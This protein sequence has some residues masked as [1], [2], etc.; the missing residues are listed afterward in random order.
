MTSE[1]FRTNPMFLRNQ[2]KGEGVFDIPLLKKDEIDLEEIALIGYDKL[3][4]E[5]YDKIVHF[6]LDDYKFEVLWRDPLPRLARLKQYKAVLTPNYSI[7]SEMPTALKIYNTFRSR[8]CGAFFQLK[9]IKVIPTVAWGEP[10]TFWFC[11]DGIPEGSIVAVSTLGVRTE[12]N[13]FLQGYNELLRRIKPEAV[14]CYGEP[15]E[16]MK[17]NI[18]AID[19]AQTN[20]YSKSH[21][22]GC[23]TFEYYDSC[24]EYG[25]FIKTMICKIEP[26]RKGMG[27]AT[28]GNGNSSSE[29][30]SGSILKKKI[31]EFSENVRNA[32]KKYKE[33]GWKG[34]YSGQ[35]SGTKA[36]KKYR[37]SDNQLPSVDYNGR[38]IE[39]YEFD[40]NDK[41][42]NT[43]RDSERFVYGSD[44]SVFYTSDHYQTF[45]EVIE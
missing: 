36:G 29:N 16:E 15:F 10:D 11:F 32:Y 45:T 20:G 5:E 3:N 9:G 14:I 12:K 33:S 27:S 42:P 30:S 23:S 37:N 39:Y 1:S 26:M 4:E 40:V 41:L 34:N 21:G 6:F 35:S 18:I 8:W 13:L 17:G 24:S 19:Y 28:R 25:Q 43:N 38:N 22:Y 44:G 7:Y 2:F 31:Q